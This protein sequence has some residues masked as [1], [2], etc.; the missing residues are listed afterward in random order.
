V[1]HVAH[2]DVSALLFRHFFVKKALYCTFNILFMT[3]VQIGEA[4]KQRRQRL[5]IRQNDLA[6]LAGISLRTLVAIENGVG[7]PS[8]ETLTRLVDVLGLQLTLTI[9]S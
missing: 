3:L 2:L 4:I 1:Q 6:E 5:H 9:K 8:F 7:N